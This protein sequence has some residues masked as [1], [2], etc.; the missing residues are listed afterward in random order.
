[1]PKNTAKPITPEAIADR[2]LAKHLNPEA[3]YNAVVNVPEAD[4]RAMEDAVLGET[5]N[6]ALFIA[7]TTEADQRE[8][9]RQEACFRLGLEIGKRIGGVR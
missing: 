6:N 3:L 8:I 7:S 1:M 9:A 5:L 4:F 2:L